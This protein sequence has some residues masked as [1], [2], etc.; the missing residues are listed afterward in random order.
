MNIRKEIPSVDAVNAELVKNLLEDI[1]KKLL[2]VDEE[3]KVTDTYQEILTVLGYSYD[4]EKVKQTL[5]SLEPMVK[6]TFEVVDFSYSLFVEKLNALKGLLA[7]RQM[8]DIKEKKATAL[9]KNQKLNREIVEL[10]E[11]RNNAAERAEEIHKVVDELS[12]EEYEKVGPV[13]K[14]YYDKLS[15]FNVGDS[16]NL[17]HEKDGI[18]LVDDKGKSIVNILSNGQITVFMLAYFFAGISSRSN[19]EKMKIYFID[20]LTACMDDVNM[21]AF[22][23]IIKYQ[24]DSKA[25]I[26]QLFFATCDDRI[27]GLLEYKMEGRGIKTRI[28]T[29]EEFVS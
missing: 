15:R 16:F 14:K 22:L 6:Q 8:L 10:E 17:K 29:E 27:S 13:L 19:R 12:M 4:E 20:D 24:M 7:N 28:I 26:D 1:D 18:S 21:L 11:L 3:K 23:D 25:T 9:E 5:A 2:S